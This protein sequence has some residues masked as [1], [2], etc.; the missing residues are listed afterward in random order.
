MYGGHIY[1]QSVTVNHTQAKV[2]SN[3]HSHMSQSPLTSPSASGFQTRMLRIS[4]LKTHRLR[5]MY[6]AASPLR[7]CITFSLPIGII[8]LLLKR[9]LIL[10]LPVLYLI[11]HVNAPFLQPHTKAEGE[12]RRYFVTI[13]R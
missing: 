4:I 9:Y 7:H 2:T 6:L 11:T 10:F 13:I 1:S 8:S 12:S 3:A 5:Y